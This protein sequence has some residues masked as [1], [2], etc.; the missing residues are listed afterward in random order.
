MILKVSE[1]NPAFVPCMYNS[2]KSNNQLKV[3]HSSI[4]SQILTDNHDATC[5]VKHVDAIG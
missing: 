2:N 4:S 1:P 3:I 5:I